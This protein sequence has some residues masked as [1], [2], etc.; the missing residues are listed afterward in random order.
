MTTIK[1]KDF[2]SCDDLSPLW[3]RLAETLPAPLDLGATLSLGDVAARLGAQN[4]YWAVQ[5]ILQD[6]LWATAHRKIISVLLLSVKRAAPRA[7]NQ[8][9]H[10]CVRD[11]T[12]WAAGDNNIDLDEAL[13]QISDSWAEKKI[14]V[15]S[16]A[17]VAQALERAVQAEAQA[18]ARKKGLRAMDAA[19]AAELAAQSATWAAHAARAKF[20]YDL[21]RSAAWA[22]W[23]AQEV[24]APGEGKAEEDQMQIADLVAAFPPLLP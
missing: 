22:A 18:E 6:D 15:I 11:L 5:E 20:P 7:A 21:A 10:Y 4:A 1:V 2:L 9:F 17:R 16:A 19:R 3:P 23:A 14:P 12:K 13:E 8:Q 24:W